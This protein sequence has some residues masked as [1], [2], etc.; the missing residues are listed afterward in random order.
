M[1]SLSIRARALMLAVVPATLIS[2]L[3]VGFF[4]FMRFDDLESALRQRGHAL[5]RQLVSASEFNLFSG[6]VEALKALAERALSE[7]DVRGVAI[8][9]VRA[10]IRVGAGQPISAPLLPA[11]DGGEESLV[12]T[13]DSIV[14][15]QPVL[16]T[17][18]AL[19]DGDPA[20]NARPPEVIGWVTVELSTRSMQAAKQ[21]FLASSFAL[22]VL[23]LGIALILAFGI[24]Q[25][26]VVPL[27]R[28]AAVIA[29]IGRGDLAARVAIEDGS[30]LRQVADGLN[31]MA[32]RL[33]T[34]HADMRRQIELAT[35][36]LA[37]GKGDAE[38]AN[39]AKSRFLA[40]ASHDLRQ[41]MHALGLFV[42][43]LAQK[44]HAPDTAHLVRRIGQSVE[45]LGSLLDSLL[46]ISRLDAGALKPELRVF[47]LQSLFDRIETDF[48]AE[49]EAKG[50]R[51]RLRPTHL[52]VRSDATLLERVLRNLLNNAVRYTE[53]GTIMLGARRRG[54]RLRIEVRDSGMGIPAASQQLI[55]QEF[56]QLGNPE[57]NRDK[58]LG[59]GLAIVQ[60]LGRLLEHPIGV[61]SRD[62]RG[63]VFW[64]E[65]PLAVPAPAEVVVDV[66]RG[67][68]EGRA[69]VLIDDDQL[70]LA[71]MAAL[72]ESWDCRVFAAESCDKLERLLAAQAVAPDLIICDH[73]LQD[74]AN[75][76]DVVDRL[77]RKHGANVPAVLISGDT[78]AGVWKLASQRGFPLLHKPVR[79][80]KLRAALR[81]L[82]DQAAEST[83]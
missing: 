49:T 72:L 68:I 62:G 21:S 11:A 32:H 16:Q 41:P 14:L 5:A 15:A 36:E 78:D 71:S 54:D 50:L 67:G 76:I 60:R 20:A 27:R 30:E 7:P 3:L 70:V 43:L 37:A 39:E 77:R 18:L 29:R 58:G 33:E 45:A 64:I 25:Q 2:V 6:N 65:V 19:D 82:L 59:L 69:I 46:D 55:F 28:M 47:A 35:Q 79:P 48:R 4:V 53:R 44:P 26:I 75:G 12:A 24:G 8:R 42:D 31:D 9:G 51:L 52:W 10:G 61:S 38:R 66:N 34:A 1:K 80:A 83:K 22:A 74:G 63:S 23:V 56:V 57:R 73:Q 81:A 13:A 40:A 17:Y